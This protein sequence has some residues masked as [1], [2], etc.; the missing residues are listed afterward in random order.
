MVLTYDAYSET[1]ES[2][3][4]IESQFQLQQQ[5]KS[6]Q[7]EQAE[8]KEEFRELMQAVKRNVVKGELV[9]SGIKKGDTELELYATSD[10]DFKL[11][12]EKEGGRESL[13]YNSKEAERRAIDKLERQMQAVKRNVVKGELLRTFKGGWEIYG[14]NER[15]YKLVKEK[16]GHEHLVKLPSNISQETDRK[17]IDEEL[18]QIVEIIIKRKAVK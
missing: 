14:T 18:K 6:M 15:D 12:R 1:V 2:E 9:R 5:M 17:K 8:S 16:G 3:K 4:Q 7:E 10:K 11:L 13:L